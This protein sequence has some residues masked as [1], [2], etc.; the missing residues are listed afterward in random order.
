VN[1]REWASTWSF[2]Q[3]RFQSQPKCTLELRGEEEW[4]ALKN[5]AQAGHNAAQ[6]PNP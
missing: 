5:R 1:E 4:F 6:Q 3:E 2:D